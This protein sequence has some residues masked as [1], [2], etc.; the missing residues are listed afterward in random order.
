[1]ITQEM[2]DS[3]DPFEFTLTPRESLGLHMALDKLERYIA[4]GRLGEAQGARSV[5]W[6]MWQALTTETGPIDTGWGEL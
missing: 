5:V 4:K 6:I 2:I 1:M 3:I